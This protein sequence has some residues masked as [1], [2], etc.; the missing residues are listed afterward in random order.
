[1]TDTRDVWR[2][3]RSGSLDWLRLER[4]PLARPS[5][6][7]VRV[8]VRAVGL[9]LADVFAC[10]GMY[11]AAPAAPFVPGLEVAGVVEAVP[12][13]PAAPGS[14]GGGGDAIGG[15]DNTA[16]RTSAA[17]VP[18]LRVGE[19]VI[20][21]TRFGGYATALNADAHYVR[22]LPD[23]WSFAE[24]AA[25]P[26]QAITAWYALH[27]LARIQPGESALVH[28]G[29]GG[30][31]LNALAL[32]RQ[33][34]CP[35]ITTVGSEA[36][37][38]FLVAHAHLTPEQVI[39]RSRRRFGGQLDAALHTLGLGG[40]DV[41]L[42][43]IAGPYFLPAYKRL[44]AEGRIVIFGASDMMPGGRRASRLRLLPRYLRRPRLDPMRMI[45]SNRSV[46]GFNLIYLW[47]RLDRLAALYDQVAAALPD[48]PLVGRTY[49]FAEAMAALR[50]MK[51]GDSVGK[52]VLDVA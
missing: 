16:T 20:A 37:R 12:E 15:G 42:D 35:V 7:Q 3:T 39:V 24:G 34:G 49:P 40:F 13:A 46:A 17:R 38:A 48:P 25:F 8:G 21:L 50:W 26:V 4:E 19:R 27:G 6:G 1:M 36:K 10:L 43:A 14:P 32:L 47:D 11:S 52:V 29:A 5:P 18:N 2:I 33:A 30:V 45:S 44:R 51:S 23:R 28:S 31:G 9:N 41:V 22:R